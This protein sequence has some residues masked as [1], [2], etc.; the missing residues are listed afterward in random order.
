MPILFNEIIMLIQLVGYVVCYF[1]GLWNQSLWP[2][3]ASPLQCQG[4][5]RVRVGRCN[6]YLRLI[7]PFAITKLTEI[8]QLY[9]L[10]PKTFDSLSCSL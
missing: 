4:Q 8:P 3:D 7:L 2:F 5:D 10:E 1:A 6:Q 9:I